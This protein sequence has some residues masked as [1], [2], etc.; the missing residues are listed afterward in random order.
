MSDFE[1]IVKAKGKCCI[2]GKSL[3]DCQAVNLV[4][5]EH[6]ATWEFPVWGNVLL[7][8][9]AK[10]ALAVVHDSCV[11]DGCV[12][13]TIKHAIEFSNNELIYHEVPAK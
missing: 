13:G 4:Q 5:L 12:I 11:E 9:P 10:F 2:T 6:E 3:N 1:K 7:R 8:K